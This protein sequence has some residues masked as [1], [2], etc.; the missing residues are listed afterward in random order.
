VI[1]Q[2][3]GEGL[4]G[5]WVARNNFVHNNTI[6]H[7]GPSGMNVMVADHSREWFDDNSGNAFNYNTYVVPHDKRGYFV[8]TDGRARFS[9]LPD[10]AMEKEGKAQVASREPMKLECSRPGKD[11]VVPNGVN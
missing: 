2:K 3:R 7:L 1:N 11:L 8:V 4:Y 5:P 9:K 6:I 10:Y